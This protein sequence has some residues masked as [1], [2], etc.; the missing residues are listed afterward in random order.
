M[1][2]NYDTS[3]LRLLQASENVL[4]G[5]G[6]KNYLLLVFSDSPSVLD[7]LQSTLYSTAK[8]ATSAFSLSG[9]KLP[10]LILES[11]RLPHEQKI[12]KKCLEANLLFIA[13]FHYLAGKSECQRIV[14]EDIL[15]VRIRERKATVIFTQRDIFDG[16]FY[17][18]LK[19]LLGTAEKFKV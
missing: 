16:C 19:V 5:E 14:L 8:K 13:D 12:M 17:E 6:G 7:V 3:T 15:Q 10:T 11:M 9:E 4:L 1:E 2:Q 18:N